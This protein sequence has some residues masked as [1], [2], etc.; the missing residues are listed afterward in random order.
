MYIQQHYNDPELDLSAVSQQINMNATYFSAL[1]KRET[2][3]CF[4]EYLTFLRMTRAK[5]L[6]KATQKR[7]SDIAFEVGYNDQNYFS[8][9]FKKYTGTSAREFRQV[10]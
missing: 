4:I 8:K 2:G 6:L 3:Q 9:L 1:F 5:E 10:D 7:T